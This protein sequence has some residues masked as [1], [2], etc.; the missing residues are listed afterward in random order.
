MSNDPLE[1]RPDKP[2]RVFGGY[3]SL[4]TSEPTGWGH[5]WIS[6]LAS[7]LLGILGL[8]IVLCFRFPSL[9][10][11]ADLRFLYPVVYVRA[12]LHIVLI[13]S[14]LLG[15]TSIFLRQNKT[16][17]LVAI[18]CTLAAALLGGATA[19]IG[20]ASGGAVFGLDWFAMNLVLYS[21][22]YIPL[23]RL[24]AKRP[25]QPV[26]RKQ[27]RV[28]LTYFFFNTLLIQITSFLT[29]HPAMVF[30]D[31]AR[32]PVVEQAVTSWP[33][34]VQIPLC[35]LV[36]DLAQYWVHRAFHSVPLLWRFHA[37]HHSAES[38]DW[39]AG[40]RLHIVDAI[41]TRGLTYVPLYVLG[42]SQPAIVVYVV[43]VAVQATFIHAN[44][45]WEFPGVRR[46]VAT[47]CFHH[48]HHS[49][50]V[51]ARDKNFSVHSPLWDWLFGTYY[52][53]G[54]WPTSYGLCDQRKVPASWLMQLVDPLR[55][56]RPTQE[57]VVDEHTDNPA[58]QA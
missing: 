14:F 4:E 25:E 49:A 50:E 22:I 30:F 35:L 31:W 20:D 13:A 2:R 45:R 34:W 54:R 48:W 1:P 8:G 27:W 33:L 29:L 16:F 26:F 3:L 39:L 18:T 40:A 51:K 21:I 5:G 47:P 56:R 6:G 57:M 42:F 28:D 23:E 15:V 19:A 17:G 37:I 38:M 10:T 46:V 41:A 58:R 7:A 9:L 44:V 24:F 43:V 36:A 53:P 11:M 52:M 55:R 32:L 12:A